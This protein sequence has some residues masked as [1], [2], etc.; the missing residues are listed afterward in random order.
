[1]DDT[2]HAA[3][4][5][6]GVIDITTTGWSSGLSRRLEIVYHVF[7]G[8]IYISGMPVAGR[9]RAWLKNLRANPRMTFHLTKGPVADLPATARVIDD[10]AERHEI[11]GHVARVWRRDPAEMEAHSP[12]IEV[13]VEGYEAGQGIAAA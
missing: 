9:E 7:D 8:R 4:Q 6:G 5:R 11:L 12:L 13:T 3:L 2:I 10:P 1:M